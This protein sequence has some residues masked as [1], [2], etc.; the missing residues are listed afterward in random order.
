[1]NVLSNAIDALNE[2]NYGRS[3]DDIEA[4]PNIITITTELTK[5]RQSVAIKIKDN[6]KGI[7]EEVKAHIFDHL[8]T[9][10]LVGQWTGLGLSISRRIVEE[11]HGGSLTCS[12]MLGDGTEF[13]IATVGRGCHN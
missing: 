6:G 9:T 1:M 2:C 3:Y 13:T 8:F 12:S 7:L 4:A 10:K 5:D 11:I